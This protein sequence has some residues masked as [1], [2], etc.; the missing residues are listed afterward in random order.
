MYFYAYYNLGFIIIEIKDDENTYKNE[1]KYNFTVAGH[2]LQN[3]TIPNL[4]V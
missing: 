2:I 1:A 3:N 4:I